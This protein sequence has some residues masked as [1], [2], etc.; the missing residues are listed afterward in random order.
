MDYVT[1]LLFY[2]NIVTTLLECYLKGKKK[3]MKYSYL[4]FYSTFTVYFNSKLVNFSL[5]VGSQWFMCSLTASTDMCSFNDMHLNICMN[6]THGRCTTWCRIRK[7]LEVLCVFH[8]SAS[9][10][11]SALIYIY[12]SI[13]PSSVRLSSC[14]KMKVNKA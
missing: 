9:F 8:S 12:P 4:R 2:L 3:T 7:V 13:L 6:I 5:T 1:Y 14:S 11:S 10:L